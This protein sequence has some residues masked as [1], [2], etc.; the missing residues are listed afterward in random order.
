MPYDTSSYVPSVAEPVVETEKIEKP[1]KR[2]RNRYRASEDAVYEIAG[3][4]RAGE[5][6]QSPRAFP[7]YEVA[8]QKALVFAEKHLRTGYVPDE[9]LGAFPEE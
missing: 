4:R 9:W 6:Y 8:E 3:F 1:A 2:W 7:S 5:E